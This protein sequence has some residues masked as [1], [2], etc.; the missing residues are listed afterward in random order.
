MIKNKFGFLLSVISIF[1]VLGMASSCYPITDKPSATSTFH[2]STQIQSLTKTQTIS[3][4]PP[5]HTPESTPSIDIPPTPSNQVLPTGTYN[6]PQIKVT[7]VWNNN[8]DYYGT[9]IITDR[10]E[11]SAFLLYN[12]DGTMNKTYKPN[13]KIYHPMMAEKITEGCDLIAL[14]YTDMGHKLIQIDSEGNIQKEI[15]QLE[16]E[17]VNGNHR[18]LPTISPSEDYVTYVVFSGELYYDTAQYQDI[19]V[20]SLDQPDKPIRITSHGGAWNHGGAWSPDGALIAYS[21]YD[22]QGIL[23][24][25]ITAINTWNQVQITEF[26]NSEIKPG[27]ISWSPRGD[28]LVVML[29]DKNYNR[30][31]WIVSVP[32]SNAQKLDLPEGVVTIADLIYWSNVGSIMLL[33][34]G[35]YA[36]SGLEGLYWF[37]IEH[38]QLIHVITI[39][40][41][42]EV[43]SHI[44]LFYAPI[45]VTT[46][47]SKVIF[48]GNPYEWFLYDATSGV[49]TPVSW[50]N[51]RQWG[52]NLDVSIFKEN[53]FSCK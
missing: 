32:Q 25:Y 13:P 41:A 24:V 16:F 52:T 19:E 15:F 14:V 42:E 30:E 36:E 7:Y 18:Y 44:G 51:S 21:D 26:T 9:I 8:Q 37:D 33:S 34:V 43:N 2:V 39:T 10:E 12:S 3:P 45:P 5:R 29:E 31:V 11:D 53:I 47:L 50:L 49:L 35:D 27:P 23:Q 46:N 1:L 28:R 4:A 6:L 48:N 38:N 17:D 40:R 20:V 22:D